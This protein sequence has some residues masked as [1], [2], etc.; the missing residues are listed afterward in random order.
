MGFFGSIGN[1]AR[2]VID[3]YKQFNEN[4][5]G[6]I[7]ES[8]NNGNYFT[9]FAQGVFTAAANTVMA[10]AGIFAAETVAVADGIE[11][12]VD[13]FGGT[14]IK[15][16]QFNEF[17]E[18]YEQSQKTDSE[19]TAERKA[20]SFK[21]NPNYKGSI[22]DI[23]KDESAK[24][25]NNKGYLSNSREE[26]VSSKPTDKQQDVIDNY[27]QS[28]L[29]RYPGEVT[30]QVTYKDEDGNLLKEV[31]KKEDENGNEYSVTIEYDE[32]GRV[33]SINRQCD[34]PGI[35]NGMKTSFTYNEDGS[36]D[37]NQSSGSEHNGVRANNAVYIEPQKIN[38]DGSMSGNG[39]ASS[40][41][42]VQV[43]NPKLSAAA[44]RMLG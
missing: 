31:M 41:T 35:N 28:A 6:K 17:V 37:V 2:K 10:P 25:V 19:A 21:R 34:E 40:I 20:P 8:I 43:K 22:S 24:I 13:A 1:M 9:A 42:G 7:K 29:D 18:N 16:N 39:V 23:G 14:S 3:D 5:K 27:V 32:Q 38:P 15:E 30:D 26:S 36:I 44:A 4:Q 33:S 12:A 11:S